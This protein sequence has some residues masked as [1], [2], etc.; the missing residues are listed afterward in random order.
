MWKHWI[1][2]IRLLMLTWKTTQHRWKAVQIADSRRYG[3]FNTGSGVVPI[4]HIG[5][6]LVAFGATLRRG[7]YSS[8]ND[9]SNVWRSQLWPVDLAVQNHEAPSPASALLSLSRKSAQVMECT[10]MVHV[11]SEVRRHR[12]SHACPFCKEA[13]SSDDIFHFVYFPGGRRLL[14]GNLLTGA[15]PDI[16]PSLVHLYGCLGHERQL[17]LRTWGSYALQLYTAPN[18]SLRRITH[19]AFTLFRWSCK[20]G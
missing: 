18:V 12:S 11:I 19:A 13:D 7:A 1:P 8:T 2:L 6:A 17:I 16:G 3:S 5:R 10:R 20:L 4:R 9:L 14:G 15:T